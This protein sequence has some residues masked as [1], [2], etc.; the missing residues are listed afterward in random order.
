MERL[1]SRLKGVE[2]ASFAAAA[3]L[4]MQDAPIDVANYYDG[5]P[6][7]FWSMFNPYGVPEKAFYAFRAFKRLLDHPLRVA[8]QLATACDGLVAGGG[9]DPGR[10]SGCLLVSNVTG[11]DRQYDIEIVLPDEIEGS[12]CEI[13]V[14]D[15]TRDLEPEW[16]EPIAGHHVR[17]SIPIPRH[18]VL[19]ITARDR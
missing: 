8:V 14:L 1:F 2:G 18:S 3:L 5:A 10:R 12:R 11:K 19:L 6:T 9:V 17:L 16:I 4:A 7:S 13:C 15:H